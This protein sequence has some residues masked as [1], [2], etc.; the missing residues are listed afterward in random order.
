M[1]IPLDVMGTT[2]TKGGKI[3]DKN[4]KTILIIVGIVFLV[5]VALRM[6]SV[7]MTLS[8]VDSVFDRIIDFASSVGD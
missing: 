4:L 1:P 5:L 6:F 8:M 2:D 3:M 7:W